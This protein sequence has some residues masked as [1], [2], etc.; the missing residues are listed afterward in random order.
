M[1][2]VG[3]EELDNLLTTE[4]VVLV[5]F[6]AMW[7]GPCKMLMPTMEKIADEFD[8]KVSI[9]KVNIDDEP[10]LASRYGVQSIPTLI[11]F[12][13][14]KEINRSVGMVV[15]NDIAASLNVLL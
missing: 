14:G 11:Y 6:F 12:K 9:V 8:G 15:R 7:C 4:N 2:S 10:D 13:N 1:R 5:D 3:K